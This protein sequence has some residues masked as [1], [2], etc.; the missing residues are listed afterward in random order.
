MGARHILLGFE[1]FCNRLLPEACGREEFCAVYIMRNVP[2]NARSFTPQKGCDRLIINHP[3]SNH[4]WH[5][6]VIR[7]IGPW[8]SAAEEDRGKVPMCWNKDSIRQVSASVS[9]L[10]QERVLKLFNLDYK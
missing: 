5:D 8:D 10:V 9:L 2:Q 7:V 1:A 3:D 6:S 4:G